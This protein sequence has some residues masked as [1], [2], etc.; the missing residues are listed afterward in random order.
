RL[1][2]D[3]ARGRGKRGAAPGG[4][5]NNRR[6]HPVRRRCITENATMRKTTAIPIPV[7]V[8]ALGLAVPAMAQPVTATT[9]LNVRAGPG[10]Q[11]PVV[12]V[13]AAGEGAEL[14]GC[15][16][17]SKWCSLATASGEGWVYADYVSA[18]FG[19]EV[20]VLSERPTDS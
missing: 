18:D 19:G 2:P 11:Y 4:G 6:P 14:N 12:G 17:N 1:G 10:P 5:W 13:I 20:V 15:L 16:E 8:L 3:A 9:D 7:V